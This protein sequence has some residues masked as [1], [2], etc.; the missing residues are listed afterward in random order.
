MNNTTNN[1]FF[2]EVIQDLCIRFILCCPEEEHESFDRLFFQIE[3]AHWFYCDFYRVNYPNQL[4][5][6]NFK[7]FAEFVFNQCPLLQPFRS[8][9]HEFRSEWVQYKTSVPVCG[10]I[11]LNK[12]MDNVLLVRGIGAG[13]SWSFPRGKINKDEQTSACAVREVKEETGL[14]IAHLIKEREFIE[15]T[16]N[17]QSVKLFIVVMDVHESAI[18]PFVPQTRG[19]IGAIEWLSIEGDVLSNGQNDKKKKKF[20]TVMPFVRQLNKWISQQKEKP[21]HIITSPSLIPHSSL[22][23]ASNQSPKANSPRR[24]KNA[25]TNIKRNAKN[26]TKRNVPEVD[27]KIPTQTR[28]PAVQPMTILK[29]GQ[30]VSHVDIRVKSSYSPPTHIRSKQQL[31]ASASPP[32]T[33]RSLPNQHSFTSPTNNHYTSYQLNPVVNMMSSKASNSLLNFAF[34][35]DDIVGEMVM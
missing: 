20:W 16:F 10:A 21:A 35:T 9:V 32:P 25:P 3:E 34:N 27:F 4:P 18:P 7:Q 26:G 5:S 8:R 14:D 11:I 31:S 28:K 2:E 13:A 15:M 23:I 6:L 12:S 33:T 24:E 22:V 19:E 17:E 29:R 1:K 30:E